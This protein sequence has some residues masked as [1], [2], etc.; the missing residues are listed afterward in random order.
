VKLD[1]GQTIQ[2]IVYILEVMR[3]TTKKKSERPKCTV[4]RNK[5]PDFELMAKAFLNLYYQTKD[6][7]IKE[8]ATS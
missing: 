4:T 3:M 1:I 2:G 5:E 8:S 6:E 7:L